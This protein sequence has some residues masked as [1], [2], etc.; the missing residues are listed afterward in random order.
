MKK[1][2]RERRRN[3]QRTKGSEIIP[4]SFIIYS[5]EINGSMKAFLYQV[6]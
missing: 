6:D 3:E 2:L 5:L 4:L 1:S